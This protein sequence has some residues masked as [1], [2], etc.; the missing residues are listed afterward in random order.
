MAKGVVLERRYDSDRV[1]PGASYTPQY[2][3]N[4]AGDLNVFPVYAAAYWDSDAGLW[5]VAKADVGMDWP[6]VYS[7]YCTRGMSVD[8]SGRGVAALVAVTS[9]RPH[10]GVVMACGVVLDVVQPPFSG[11]NTPGHKWPG[12][13]RAIFQAIAQHLPANVLDDGDDGESV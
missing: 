7:R 2:A 8:R 10:G 3:R 13:L 11:P 6:A 9:M 12:G 5:T 1:F 4:A